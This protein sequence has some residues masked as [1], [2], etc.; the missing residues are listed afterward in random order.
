MYFA[1]G[2]S[3]MSFC[4]STA[5]RPS[6]SCGQGKRSQ[7][8]ASASASSQLVP[9]L[10]AP[11]PGLGE[12]ARHY[13]HEIPTGIN[14]ILPPNLTRQPDQKHR[15]TPPPSPPPERDPGPRNQEQAEDQA[16]TQ[17]QPT[18]NSRKPLD[19]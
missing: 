15:H 13:S 1:L 9:C 10:E 12:G 7:S 14:T 2:A 17:D 11:V 6:S 3:N 8:S 4:P 16:K 18:D 5:V 19:A